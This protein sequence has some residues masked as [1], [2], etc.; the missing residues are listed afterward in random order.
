MAAELAAGNRAA[1][2]RWYAR[3]REALQRELAIAPDRDTEAL[4]DQCIA[5]LQPAGP[6]FVGQAMARAR[7][8]AWL[9]TAITGRPG[10]IV[11]R[12][13]PGIGKTAFCHELGA[14]GRER[15]WRVVRVDAVQPGRA[16]AV[17]AALAEQVIMAE[18]QVLDRIGAPPARC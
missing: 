1:A 14:L 17:I 13:P 15:G 9:G 2:I 6:A 4:Y 3:L 11:L 12:G 16:F 5:G 7:A 18:R 10:G 8:A